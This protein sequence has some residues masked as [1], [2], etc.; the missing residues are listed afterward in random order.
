MQKELDY[1]GIA[2]DENL[3]NDVIESLTLQKILGHQSLAMTMRYAHLAPDHLKEAKEFNPLALINTRT[4]LFSNLSEN[5]SLLGDG[6]SALG[7]ELGLRNEDFDALKP[8]RAS[9]I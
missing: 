1:I 3:K 5:R 6:L 4:D 8:V 2:N 9:E 7:R